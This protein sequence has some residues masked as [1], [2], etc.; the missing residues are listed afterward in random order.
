MVGNNGLYQ[1]MTRMVGLWA[2][3][4]ELDGRKFPI[5]WSMITPSQIKSEISPMKIILK[6]MKIFEY[7]RFTLNPIVESFLASNSGSFFQSIMYLN[8]RSP[9]FHIQTK[10]SL[11]KIILKYLKISQ[12]LI[13]FL[14]SKN[15][16][17]ARTLVLQKFNISWWNSTY[18]N[19]QPCSS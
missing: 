5:P 15:S 17:S 13:R 9:T 8:C 19:A 10:S 3:S 18:E 4:W 1:L 11:M 12:S 2:D 7:R 6:H 16:F 14:L